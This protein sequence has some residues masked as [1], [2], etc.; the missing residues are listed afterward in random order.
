MDWLPAPMMVR[1]VVTAG[2]EYEIAVVHVQVPA[3]IFTVAV[4]LFTLLKA[5]EISVCEQLAA[6]MVCAFMFP[7]K[8]AITIST[9]KSH[10]IFIIPT[11]P[12]DHDSTMRLAFR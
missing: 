4:A 6:L 7:E 1:L 8:G 9:N 2:V 12:F 10:F 11:I 3:G 5:E